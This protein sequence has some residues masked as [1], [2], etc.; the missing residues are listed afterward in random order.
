[1]LL[2]QSGGVCNKE[3]LYDRLVLEVGHLQQ[4]EER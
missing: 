3:D 1:M 2:T 4:R